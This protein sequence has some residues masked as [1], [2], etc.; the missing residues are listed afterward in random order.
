MLKLAAA[1]PPIDSPTFE[2][3]REMHAARQ[4]ADGSVERILAQRAPFEVAQL[5]S[6]RSK[7]V[8]VFFTCRLFSCC[9]DQSNLRKP[10][11]EPGQNGGAGATYAQLPHDA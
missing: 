8:A 3:I 7:D 4:A 1:L 2:A 5:Q 9:D 10:N 11:P 6:S